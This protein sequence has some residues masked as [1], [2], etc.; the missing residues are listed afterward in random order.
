M[1]GSI[2]IS[3]P[4]LLS[5]MVFYKSIIL[6]VDDSDNSH[7]GFIL[8]KPGGL[9]FLKNESGK[10]NRNYKFSFGGPVSGETFFIIKN[11]NLYSQNLEINKNL[12]WG[13]DVEM[14]VN[15][16]ENKKILSK[17]VLFFQGYAGWE[18][19]QLDD[20]LINNS[21]IVIKNYEGDIF[22]LTHN[23]S[24]NKIIKSLGDKY[25]IWANSPDDI[26]QN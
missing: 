10:L 14:V 2:L 18:K 15:E 3:S 25:T 26:S 1:K 20:E 19:D 23:N 7:T 5:D 21:W 12:F 24:W 17:D 11:H 4:S 13:N 8:N 22:D 16:I 6:I 9:F